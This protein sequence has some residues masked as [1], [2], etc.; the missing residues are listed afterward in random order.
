VDWLS[1]VQLKPDERCCRMSEDIAQ[2]HADMEFDDAILD[3]SAGLE[4][5]RC[6]LRSSLSMSSSGSPPLSAVVS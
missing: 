5:L 4:R 6:Q 1:T 2:Q 3:E